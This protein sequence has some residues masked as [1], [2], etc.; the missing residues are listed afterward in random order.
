MDIYEHV[1]E[2]F[3]GLGLLCVKGRQSAGPPFL[4]YSIYYSKFGPVVDFLFSVLYICKILG[5]VRIFPCFLC[6]RVVVV[7]ANSCFLR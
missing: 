7:F 4:Y 3:F 2:Y 5:R 6:K 1:V